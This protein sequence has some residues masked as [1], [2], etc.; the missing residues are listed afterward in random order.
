[1]FGPKGIT[2]HFDLLSCSR[3]RC[4]RKVRYFPEHKAVRAIE[5]LAAKGVGK[6][7]HYQCHDCGGF[8]LT[9]KEKP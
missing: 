8:H 3:W 5:K 6:F 7:S 1:M 2:S 9:H 4:D